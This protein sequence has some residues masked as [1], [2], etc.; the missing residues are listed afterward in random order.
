MSRPIYFYLGMD[1]PSLR[2]LIT[3][4]SLFEILS[5]SL[6]LY[7]SLLSVKHTAPRRMSSPPR[8]H[9]PFLR[10]TCPSQ[11]TEVVVGVVTHPEP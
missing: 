9:V 7:V 3:T 4:V 2:S 5:V 10:H 11:P 1:L 8:S 6:L